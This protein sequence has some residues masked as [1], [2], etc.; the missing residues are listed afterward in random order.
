MQILEDKS[1]QELLKSL[2]A[3][4]AKAKNEVKCAEGDLN[5]AQN[6]LAFVLMLLNEL[7]NRKN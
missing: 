6:R 2:I 4:A 7:I 5:K 3:E 1:D